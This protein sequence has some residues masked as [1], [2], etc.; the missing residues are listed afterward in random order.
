MARG[1]KKDRLQPCIQP[2]PQTAP[3]PK[4]TKS[5]TAEQCVGLRAYGRGGL[6]SASV[7]IHFLI[8]GILGLLRQM[9][10]RSAPT[11]ATII[12]K[13][14]SRGRDGF[15]V[16]ERETNPVRWETMSCFLIL[17]SALPLCQV[18]IRAA[19]FAVQLPPSCRESLAIQVVK[20]PC[21]LS[22]SF[23]KPCQLVLVAACIVSVLGCT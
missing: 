11:A 8:M 19:P 12:A 7:D 23:R 18:Y 22:S 2:N 13:A 3:R 6:R 14:A 5:G 17:R 10:G 1:A 21:R 9:V 15:W 4:R 20:V 16:T